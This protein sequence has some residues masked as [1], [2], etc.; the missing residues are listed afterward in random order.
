MPGV[1]EYQTRIANYVFWAKPNSTTLR[2][3][4]NMAKGLGVLF[5]D[6]IKS[7]NPTCSAY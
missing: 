1:P 2:R 6:L 3:A 5:A 7:P 4:L